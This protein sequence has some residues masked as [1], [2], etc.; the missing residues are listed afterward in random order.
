MYS[1]TPDIVSISSHNKIAILSPSEIDTL[2]NGTYQLLAEV[3]VRYP[4]KRALKIF[5]DHGAE[6]DQDGNSPPEYCAGGTGIK[7]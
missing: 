6:V 2:K 7:I 3:G 5:A 1:R 4:S